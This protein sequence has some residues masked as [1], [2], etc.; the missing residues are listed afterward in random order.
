MSRLRR[1]AAMH[2]LSFLVWDLLL[3]GK[4]MR[5]RAPWDPL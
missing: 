2:D 4:R 3:V 1:V 5:K